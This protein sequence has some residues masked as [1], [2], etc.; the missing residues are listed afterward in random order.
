M[1]VT[2]VFI[3]ANLIVLL[4]VGSVD[5]GLVGRHRRARTFEPKDY[6][7]LV[8]FIRDAG[9]VFVTPNV[10]TEASNL[11]ENPNDPR[12]LEKLRELIK[13]SQETAVDST[14]AAHNSGFIRLGLTDA[15]L[16]EVVSAERPL[17]TNDLKLYMAAFKKGQK[18]PVAINFTHTQN[19]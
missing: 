16:L 14:R 9:Q 13:T 5:R 4:V 6:D 17:L 10:L 19:L 7:R 12:F 11:L 18:A 2:G 15:G 3:D 8:D 1:R